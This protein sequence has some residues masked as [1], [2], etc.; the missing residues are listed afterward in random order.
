MIKSAVQINT[1]LL[2]KCN[3]Q[4]IK[5]KNLYLTILHS[6]M[7]LIILL[8]FNLNIFVYVRFKLY[9]LIHQTHIV[10]NAAFEKHENL[11]K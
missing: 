6:K 5:K 1:Y 10:I 11:N 7:N 4:N 2:L 9:Y 8:Y 3:N